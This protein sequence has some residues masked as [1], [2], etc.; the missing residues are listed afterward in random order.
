M[1]AATVLGTERPRRHSFVVLVSSMS[2]TIAFRIGSGSR[3]PRPLREK[4][5]ARSTMIAAGARVR[6]ECGVGLA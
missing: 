5:T 4:S 2:L 1:S 6:S 3:S